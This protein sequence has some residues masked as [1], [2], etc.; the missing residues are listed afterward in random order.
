MIRHAAIASACLALAACN[1][2]EA[3]KGDGIC[4]QA[5][6]VRSGPPKFTQLAQGVG[7]LDDCA[8]LLEAAR[9]QGQGDTDGAYQGFFLFVDANQMTSGT[10]K[11][12][13][14]YP[15]L[16]PPQRAAIDRDL[17]KIMDAHGGKIPA[18]AGISIERQ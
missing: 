1:Q 17:H 4:W 11:D 16:Q 8:V 2:G 6:A 15:V 7:S 5:V 12:G 18:D 13:F 3:P 10:R 14:R 9:L